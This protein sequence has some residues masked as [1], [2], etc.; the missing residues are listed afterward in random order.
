MEKENEK[1]NN[2]FSWKQMI[3]VFGLIFTGFFIASYSSFEETQIRELGL[4][5]SVRCVEWGQPKEVSFDDWMNRN[6]LWTYAFKDDEGK[7][8][9]QECIGVD[10]FYRFSESKFS[11]D[12]NVFR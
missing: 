8:F 1:E 6:Q 2:V 5:D 10:F 4:V 3:V 9:V 11:L 12:E 7:M